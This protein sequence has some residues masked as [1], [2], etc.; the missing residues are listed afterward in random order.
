MKTILS[1]AIVFVSMIAFASSAGHAEAHGEDAIP[2]GKI[3][4]QA[5][6]LGILLIALFYFVRKSVVEAFEQRQVAYKEQSQKTAEALKLAEAELKEIKEKLSALEGSES[7]SIHTAQVEAEKTKSK[8]IHEASVQAEK[9]KTDVALIIGAEVYKAKNEIRN[10]IIEKS[11]A[12]AKESVRGSAQAITE[13]S[14][15]GF[16]SD[17]GQVK[18]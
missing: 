6:N 5:L 3:G 1:L 18:A 17:L 10:Q 9:L 14:G 15:A 7:A 16:I 12:T 8:M 13:K 2:F 4:I 11:I